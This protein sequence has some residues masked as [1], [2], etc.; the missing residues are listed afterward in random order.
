MTS[1]TA[2]VLGRDLGKRICDLIGLDHYN[3]SNIT[4]DIPVDDLARL[5]IDIVVT[6]AVAA[7]ITNLQYDLSDATTQ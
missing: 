4:I 6:E 3:V 1:P 5:H 7:V 2:F